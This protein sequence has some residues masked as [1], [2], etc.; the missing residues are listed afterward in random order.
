MVKWLMRPIAIDADDA[1]LRRALVVLATANE[2]KPL[3]RGRW[4]VPGSDGQ[5]RYIA[6]AWACSCP[7]ANWHPPCKHVL[8][9]RLH[10]A[11]FHSA[12]PSRPGRPERP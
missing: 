1:K 6:S 7:S 10:E 3:S 4:L 11:K 2:W 9:V 12:Q 5:Q 8:A